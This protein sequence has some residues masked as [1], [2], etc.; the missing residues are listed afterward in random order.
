MYILIDNDVV[1]GV[2][3]EYRPGA[4]QIQ[5]QVADDLEPMPHV[6]D[7]YSAGEFTAPPAV[8]ATPPKL[9]PIQFKLCFTSTERIAISALKATD[10]VIADAYE[11]LDDPRLTTVDLALASN[12]ALIDYLVALS[13][14]TPERAAQIKQGLML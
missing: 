10:P 9:S 13:V 4:A 7:I 14:L 1:V 6:G 11:I 12:Q 3:P 2:T 5:M 8:T